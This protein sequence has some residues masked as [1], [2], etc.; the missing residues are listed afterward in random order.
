MKTLLSKLQ[1]LAA[2]YG[3]KTKIEQTI[4]GV[5]YLSLNSRFKPLDKERI[6]F[7]FEGIAEFMESENKTLIHI[8]SE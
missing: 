5:Q 8:K 3:Y 6:T 7:E 2:K 4:N 1:N